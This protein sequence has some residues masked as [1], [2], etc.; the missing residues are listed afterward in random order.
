MD[1][2]NVAQTAF[3]GISNGALYAFLGLGFSLVIRSTGLIN[4]A[5]GDLMMLGGILT[6]ALCH[7][8]L[9]VAVSAPLAIAAT[10]LLSAGFYWFAI[11]P[12]AGATMAQVVLL[13]IGFAICLRGLVTIGW[14][15]EP[16]MVPSFTGEMPFDLFG[17]SIL[18]Q[19]VWLIGALVLVTLAIGFFFRRT[20]LGL[21]LRA[22]A[23]NPLGASF[24]GI[25][26]RILGLTAFAASGF[27]GAL[28]GAIWS[29][30]SFAQVDVGLGVALKG[31]TAAILGGLHSNYGPILGGIVLALIESFSAGYISSAYMDSIT[32][33]LMLL[34][35]VLR[36]Q[37]LLGSALS[38]TKDERPEEIL[39]T[40]AR[41]TGFTIRDGAMLAILVIALTGLGLVMN[42]TWLTSGIFAG[43]MAIV[44]MGLVLLTGYGG[45]LSLG[46]GAFMMIGAYATGYLTVKLNWP[47]YG[48][49]LVGVVLAAGVAFILG[50]LIFV[51]RG[52]YMSMASFGLLM[53]SLTF[54]REWT[55]ITGG[56]SGLPG[57]SPL[58]IG[59]FVF[60]SDRASY[61][62]I[63]GC[64]LLALLFCLSLARSR[65]GR[66]LL[67][68]RSNELA[69]RA[70]GVDI[71]KHKLRVFAVSAALASIAGSLYGHYLGF[72]NPLPFGIDA[73]IAQLTALTAGGFLSLSG[74]Y[75]GSAVVIALPLVITKI[76]GTT[77]SQFSAGIQ[78]VAFGV[79]LVG[80]VHV[81]TNGVAARVSTALR[82]LLPFGTRVPVLLAKKEPP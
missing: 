4:F 9:P 23:T 32:F 24:V 58:S 60:A 64:S 22:G 34:V 51:L 75:V 3:A 77:S 29:P 42:G 14:G 16:M 82:R 73:T 67:A 26:P 54:A 11:R 20:I 79:L 13:T 27:L 19:E 18:P 36:P 37:G 66:A 7:A 44:V 12:A 68:I 63:V 35:L 38:L 41:P 56:P 57:I 17:V 69:A 21:A 30:I 33:G 25:D 70:C 2:T 59:G 5:Q 1:F 81:Q 15:S 76:A 31:F 80:I 47:S 48:A 53:I 8:G 52:L 72:V 6:G 61:F 45:Q 74:A 55:N 10:T 39:S 65:I 71:T 28:A 62:L 78:Y 46:Q 40:A 50:R 49:M 43:I